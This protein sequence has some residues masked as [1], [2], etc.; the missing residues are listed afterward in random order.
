MPVYRS[1]DQEALDPS[2]LHSQDT[3]DGRG[4]LCSNFSRSR[5]KHYACTRRGSRTVKTVSI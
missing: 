5:H 4:C 2:E 3:T 1:F